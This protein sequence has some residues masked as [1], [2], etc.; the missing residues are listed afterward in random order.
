MHQ[1]LPEVFGG[2]AVQSCRRGAVLGRAGVK[3]DADLDLDLD[4]DTRYAYL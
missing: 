1:V 4:L 2:R 3:W